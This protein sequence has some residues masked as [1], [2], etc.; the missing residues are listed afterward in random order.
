V[1]ELNSLA[2]LRLKTL[3]AESLR[4]S[5]AEYERL[6]SA[7]KEKSPAVTDDRI[8]ETVQRWI[9]TGIKPART[10]AEMGVLAGA[11]YQVARMAAER[12]LH[13]ITAKK[14]PVQ[15]VIDA[16]ANDAALWRAIAM[17]AVALNGGPVA[18]S[19]FE[20]A[21]EGRRQTDRKLQDI[22]Q[23][24]D[25]LLD[26]SARDGSGGRAPSQRAVAGRSGY[27]RETVRAR[28]AFLRKRGK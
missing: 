12:C 2:L 21:L 8:S 16:H 19:Y 15:S 13:I 22:Q 17:V 5:T 4:A 25:A 27:P 24:Y 26:E 1:I 11:Y 9:Q 18:E 10:H 7:L 20:D 6:M 3:L 23:A 28:W 14:P